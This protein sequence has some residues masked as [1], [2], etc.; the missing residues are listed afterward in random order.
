MTETPELSRA[1][2][3]GDLDA[4]IAAHHRRLLGLLTLKTGD[5]TEAEDLAQDALVKLVTH[6]PQVVEMDNP[7]GWL[8]TVANNSSSSLWRRTFRGRSATAR[9]AAL[10]PAE[11]DDNEAVEMLAVIQTLPVR[12]REALILRF[13]AQLSVRETA[14]A[15]RCAE[16]TVKSLTHK[17]I[18]QLR[19]QLQEEID[20]ED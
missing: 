8:A 16:G 13:Y 1:P 14:E 7:W 20:D 11:V 6:W 10:S 17:A 4:F 18:G 15:M 3:R 5:R 19:N 12:Q 9:L 2:G